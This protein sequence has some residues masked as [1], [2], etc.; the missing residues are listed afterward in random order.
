MAFRKRRSQC[1]MESA[2][3]NSFAPDLI[4]LPTERSEDAVSSDNLY[5]YQTTIPMVD[6]DYTAGS[7]TSYPGCRGCPLIRNPFSLNGGKSIGNQEIYVFINNE[8]AIIN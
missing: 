3:I 8:N 6:K 5:L 2:I 4:P 7:A 1:G